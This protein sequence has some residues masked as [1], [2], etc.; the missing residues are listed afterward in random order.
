[1]QNTIINENREQ[2]KTRLRG[3]GALTPETR[4]KKPENGHTDEFF[5][6]WIVDVYTG[7]VPPAFIVAPTE[8]PPF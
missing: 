3:M 8:L 6:Q 7:K 4:F 1:L 2:L 5:R